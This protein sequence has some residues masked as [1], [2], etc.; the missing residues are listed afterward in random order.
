MSSPN[1]SEDRP[2]VRWSV[3]LAFVNVVAAMIT[4]AVLPP[5]HRVD[6]ALWALVWAWWITALCLMVSTA[7]R[8]RHE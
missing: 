3:V 5:F 2:V 1:H 7:R 6:L 8:P 4:L